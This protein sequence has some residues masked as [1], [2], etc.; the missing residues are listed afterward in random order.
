VTRRRPSR[1]RPPPPR[2]R[3]AQGIQTEAQTIDALQQAILATINTNQ[4]NVP[5]LFAA[6]HTLGADQ[7]PLAQGGGPAVAP[8][9]GAA[10]AAV[11]AAANAAVAASDSAAAGAKDGQGTNTTSRCG[12]PRLGPGQD[13]VGW[14]GWV[15][16]RAAPP[17][18]HADARAHAPLRAR[19]CPTRP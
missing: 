12:A 17:A 14:V 15:G 2:R 16:R 11:A 6:L 18:V 1:P 10:A 13:R 19:A 3:A 8:G 9:G 4:S 5:T 7:M